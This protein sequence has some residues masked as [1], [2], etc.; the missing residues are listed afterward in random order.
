MGEEDTERLE[1]LP[2]FTDAVR[3]DTEM[4]RL[5]GWP[6]P[7][8]LEGVRHYRGILV[9]VGLMLDASLCPLQESRC[10]QAGLINS[11]AAPGCS[12]GL[13]VKVQRGRGK[14]IQQEKLGSD[15][16][17]QSQG[18]EVTLSGRDDQLWSVSSA[19]SVD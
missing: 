10:F 17:S 15:P 2:H 4:S 7:L 11:E 8:H 18:M 1:G 16:T 5:S 12:R 19:Q 3:T 14:G 9:S 6:P 13:W